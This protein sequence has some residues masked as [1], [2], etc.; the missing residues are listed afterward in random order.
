MEDTHKK[1]SSLFEIIELSQTTTLVVLDLFSF[2][3]E[4]IDGQ[5]WFTTCKALKVCIPYCLGNA[6]TISS[7]LLL[8]HFLQITNQIDVMYK[9][10]MCTNMI[11]ICGNQNQVVDKSNFLESIDWLK[12]YAPPWV[13]TS[14]LLTRTCNGEHQKGDF[15]F[16]GVWAKHLHPW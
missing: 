6:V 2:P 13:C 9:P 16:Y 7:S 15:Y 4:L 14:T 8:E 12:K 5:A 1:L 10:N 11:M 3:K